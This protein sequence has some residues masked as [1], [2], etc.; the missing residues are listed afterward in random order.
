MNITKQRHYKEI[1]ENRVTDLTERLDKATEAAKRADAEFQE[2]KHW[3]RR[4]CMLA[5]LSLSGLA[6]YWVSLTSERW[7]ESNEVSKLEAELNIIHEKTILEKDLRN[8]ELVDKIEHLSKALRAHKQQSVTVRNFLLTF[9]QPESSPGLPNDFRDWWTY[10]HM[11][12]ERGVPGPRYT[13]GLRLIEQLEH[14]WNDGN[15][16]LGRRDAA[17]TA[18][19]LTNDEDEKQL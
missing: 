17:T 6:A 4:F 12:L 5:F 11:R 8:N 7:K 1:T 13:Y 19:K 14:E 2:T 3:W 18:G 15:P 9:H 16:K 10:E